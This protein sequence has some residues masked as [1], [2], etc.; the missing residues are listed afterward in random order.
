MIYKNG[1]QQH[2][3]GWA[4]NHKDGEGTELKNENF[5]HGVWK[6]NRL[7]NHT[8]DEIPEESDEGKQ[9]RKTIQEFE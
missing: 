3:G 4:Q 5:R 6:K 9:I 7:V 2:F 1:S 8:S